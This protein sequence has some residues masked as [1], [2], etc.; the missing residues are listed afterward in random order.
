MFTGCGTAL[1]TPF[2]K[3]QSLDEAALRRLV[4]RQID[5]GINFLV[6]CGTTGE[7]PTLSRAEHLRVIEV[8][9]EEAN[10]KVPVVGGAGGYNTHEVIELARELERLGVNGILSVTPYYNKPSQEGLYQHYKAIAGATRL[11]IVVYSVQ[12]RTGVNVEPATL[13]RLAEFENIVAVKEASGNISQMANVIQEVPERFAVLSG[14]D[15]ITIPLIALGG[16]G[17]ISVVANQ[18]PA[19]MTQIAQAALRGDF[20]TARAIQRKFL[21]LMNMNF[22]ESN[23]IPVKASLGL[24]G[25]LDPVYRLPMVPPSPGNLAKIERVLESV[26]LLGGVKIAV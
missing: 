1:V 11:P 4:R 21:P 18:I 5:A 2:K 7:S 10:G 20:A 23:P 9:V 24:M 22:I 16:R 19:E 6:P 26:G 15:A 25:L 14:D 3:D 17:I 8:T 13:A 12:G